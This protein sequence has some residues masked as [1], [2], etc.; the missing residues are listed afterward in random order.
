VGIALDSGTALQTSFSVD[1]PTSVVYD[2]YTN[3]FLAASSTSNSIVVYNPATQQQVESL[4]VGINPTSIAYNSL[5]GTLVS[6]NSLSH[7]IS[8]S[9][10]VT[11][12]IRALLTLPPAPLNSTVALTQHL[13]FGLD[14]HPLTN[15]AVI[16]DTANGRVLFIPLPN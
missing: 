10:I 3:Y 4:L 2:P 14:I 13:Q 6:T 5:T 11:N 8:V 12:Q 1:V 9:D 15:L 16:A 7:T